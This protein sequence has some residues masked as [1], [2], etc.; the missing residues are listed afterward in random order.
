MPEILCQ[1]PIVKPL[2]WVNPRTVKGRKRRDIERKK[3]YAS[4]GDH[5]V[6]CGVHK[7]KARG[8]KVMEAHED[9]EIDFDKHQY[10][11]K[12]IV[13]LCH[14]CH[15]FIH[16]GRLVSMMRKGQ[17][18]PEKVEAVYEHGEKILSE[19]NLS[20]GEYMLK[21]VD[22]DELKYFPEEN[23]TRSKRHLLIEGEKHYSPHKTY[24]D[25]ANFYSN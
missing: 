22:G 18:K 2:H 21:L 7:T 11:L 12:R 4:T 20:R 16:L 17:V 3:A 10:K 24:E 13:P 15:N 9:Y 6:A 14:Y 25:W 19:N 8:R 23:G 5:C 1:P